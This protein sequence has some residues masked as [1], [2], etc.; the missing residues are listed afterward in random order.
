MYLKKDRSKVRERKR[1]IC[2]VRERK[3]ERQRISSTVRE[4]ERKILCFC[5]RNTKEVSVRCIVRK[6]E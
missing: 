6:I 5:E 2:I 1:V 4:I 3:K